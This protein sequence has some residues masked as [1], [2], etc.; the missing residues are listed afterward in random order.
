MYFGIP[1]AYNGEGSTQY[2][3]MKLGGSL[4]NVSQKLKNP[5]IKT[6][7]ILDCKSIFTIYKV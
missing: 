1:A 7:Y 5:I 4:R 2:N 3:L 6:G